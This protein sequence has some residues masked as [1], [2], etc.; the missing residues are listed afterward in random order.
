[1]Q[2]K[3]PVLAK[4]ISG[5]TLTEV[6]MSLG[7]GGLI[8]GGVLTG[9]VQSANQSEWT[10]YNLAGNSMAM[11][12]L[13]LAR[14]AK[15]DTQASPPV[16]NL[17]SARFPQTVEPLDVPLWGATPV[18]ATNTVTISTI[19]SDP[20]LRMIEV[21]TVWSFR[22]RGLYTNLTATYRAPDQ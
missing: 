2:F 5:M 6:V 12:H 7:V 9:Y 22:D 10:A 16:D 13:E 3:I 20:P 18:M 14:A 19:S 17:V 4:T 8:F 15:W 11:Q 21:Q 1:M